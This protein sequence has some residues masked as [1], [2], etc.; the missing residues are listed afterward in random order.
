[1]MKKL[2]KGGG[3]W[4]R[5]DRFWDR[6]I[7]LKLFIERIDE[8][9]HISL[10]A[11]RR[12]GKTSLMKEA[13]RQLEDRYTCVFVD[14]EQCNSAADAIATLSVKLKRYRH[15][16]DKAKDVFA[17]ILN[18][19]KDSLEEVGYDDLYVKVRAGVTSG[20]W[21][22]KGDR[23]FT[24]LSEAEKPVLL[25]LDEVPILINRMLK[26]E[27]YRITPDGKK[28]TDEFLS[29]L[30]KNSIE[31]QGKVR[32]VLSGSIGIEPVLNQAG[33]SALINNFTPF[34]L[35]PWDENT[36]VGCLRALA[37]QYSVE[38]LNNAE[39]E[40]V[41]L[42]EC[43][44]PHHVQMFFDHVYTSCIRRGNMKFDASEVKD[45]YN[46]DMLSTRGHAELTHY[47]E[48]LKL[49]LGEE[50]FP[51]AL[52][53]AT[54]AAVTKALTPEAIKAFRDLYNFENRETLD[55]IKEILWVFEHDGYLKLVDDD[56]L[57]VSRLVRDW[58][59]RRHSLSYT[60]IL[61]GSI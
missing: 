38:F 21:S 6:E 46:N 41:K 10:V 19:T 22:A 26:G 12:M 14:L 27:N 45:V 34:E 2:T 50:V 43:C 32:I 25:L 35:K 17:N 31:H 13:A 7:D 59:E 40:M 61:N 54:E 49:V 5:G 8:G 60:P 29:W 15:L 20:D 16:W 18:I 47:E 9:Q 37:N 52:G 44:I 33:L 24:I 36:S 4:V 42:L 58:W 51:L 39:Y 57:F 53:M 30:R 48:R 3:N 55:V 11:Q 23:L 56:Y 1:M 28:A